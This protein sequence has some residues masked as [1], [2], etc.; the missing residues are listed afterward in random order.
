MPR[1]G[2]ARQEST[3]TAF[4]KTRK[5]LLEKGVILCE[6]GNDSG[7]ANCNAVATHQHLAS[8]GYR[9][10]YL[11]A[12]HTCSNC[13]PIRKNQSAKNQSAK[14][15][16]NKMK[17]ELKATIQSMDRDTSTNDVKIRIQGEGAVSEGVQS[18]GAKKAAL[19]M[20]LSVK[21]LAASGLKF[22]EGLYITI[23]NEKPED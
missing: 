4:Q 15:E 5:R 2:S 17:I 6:N 11:C 14:K 16:S 18:P 21:A 20:L 3:R 13:V 19:N 10:A 1:E 9:T 23:S 8:E 12:G 7:G 22:D